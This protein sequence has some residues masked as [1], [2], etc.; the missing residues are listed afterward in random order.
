MLTLDLPA[1]PANDDFA[2]A[3][4]LPGDLSGS[5]RSENTNATAAPGEP[6][7]LPGNPALKSMAPASGVVTF[8]TEGSDF[9]TVLGAFQGSPSNPRSASPTT[10]PA[11]TSRA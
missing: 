6:P 11:A 8:N 1:L 7:I 10:T 9:D 2:T 3:T 5:I 4:P